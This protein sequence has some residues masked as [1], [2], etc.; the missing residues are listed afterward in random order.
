MLT[1]SLIERAKAL[2]KLIPARPTASW[3]GEKRAFLMCAAL[4]E[5]I[6]RGRQAEDVRTIK[7]WAQL[8]ADI[9][10]F[11]EGGRVTEKLVKQLDPPKYEHWELI[12][13]KPKPG[14]RV[15]G[16]FAK[17]DVFIGTH[18]LERAGLGGMVR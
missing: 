3:A 1:D 8:V 5:A 14:L 7:R 6:E 17:P 16:R 2:G 11:V 13:R 15:F 9:G 18:V 4:Y 10:H 12:S